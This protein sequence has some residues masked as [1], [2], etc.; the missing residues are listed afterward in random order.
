MKVASRQATT[1]PHRLFSCNSISL[2]VLPERKG[3][4]IQQKFTLS[5]TESDTLVR[6][7]HLLWKCTVASSQISTFQTRWASSELHSHDDHLR[8]C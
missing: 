1:P 6:K 4:I 5:F 7:T 2:S 3:E 8:A